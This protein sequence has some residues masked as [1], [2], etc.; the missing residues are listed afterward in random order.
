MGTQGFIKGKRSIP[1][2]REVGV[3]LFWGSQEQCGEG[4]AGITGC[5]PR[6]LLLVLPP[7]LFVFSSALSPIVQFSLVIYLPAMPVYKILW[8]DFV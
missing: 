2:C 8:R 6:A 4:E 5:H 3:G 7:E 1:R